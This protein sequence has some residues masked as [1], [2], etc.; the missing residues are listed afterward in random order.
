M[1]PSM[2]VGVAMVQLSFPFA[3][4]PNEVLDNAD[5]TMPVKGSRVQRQVHRCTKHGLW[6]VTEMARVVGPS[7]YVGAAIFYL[8]DFVFTEGRRAWRYAN[9]PGNSPYLEQVL[10]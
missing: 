8:H 2:N 7:G 9:C 1:T 10:H 3:W 6:V 4:S 5:R